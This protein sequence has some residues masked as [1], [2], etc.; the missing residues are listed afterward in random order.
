MT[1]PS[2]PIAQIKNQWLSQQVDVKYPTPESL[3]GR[4]LYLKHANTCQYQVLNLDECVESSISPD[5]IFLVDFHRL[6]VMFSLLQS[7]RWTATEE[8]ELIVEFLTQIIYSEPCELYLAFENGEPKAA[9][10]VTCSEDQ[11]LIS[12][13]VV[14]EEQSKQ[15][16]QQFANALINKL[17]VN[18]DEYSDVYL[19]I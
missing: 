8:Q 17:N 2:L 7:K 15:S 11:I 1:E 9:A 18:I 13:V 3:A 19:E 4:E 5:D 6:T 12:D 10:I 14:I 16:K